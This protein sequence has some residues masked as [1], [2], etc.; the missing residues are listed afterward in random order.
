MYKKSCLAAIK[1]AYDSLTTVEKRVA[2]YIREHSEKVILMPIA[3][4]AEQAGVAK[5]AIIR[6]SKSLGFEG[7]SELK[8]ALAV[9][10]SKNKQLNYA[11]YI[12]PDDTPGDI[13]DKLFAANVKTLHDTADRIDREVFTAVVDLLSEARHIYIYGVGTSTVFVQELQYRLMHLG[14][15]ALAV[16]DVPSMKVSTLNIKK[17]DVAIGISHSGRT[18][19]TVETLELAKEH[20]AAT[21]CITST[22]GS[23]IAQIADY[24]IELWS[25]EIEY[26]MEA[27]SARIAHLAIIDAITVAISAKNYE[28]ALER[29]KAAHDMIDQTIRMK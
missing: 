23:K 4:F 7:Y 19:P 22:P 2:D 11:P 18:I 15:H 26:P 14:R 25:D 5:S 28:Q 6:C 9:E 8:I 3:D 21:V 17:N 13:L 27:I 16:T 24:P 12:S 20:G 29:Y 1:A 10:L